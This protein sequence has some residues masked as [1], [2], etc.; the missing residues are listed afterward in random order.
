MP[1]TIAFFGATGGCTLACL[2]HTLNAGHRAIALARNPEKLSEMLTDRDMGLMKKDLSIVKG[3]VRNVED[4]L[5]VLQTAGKSIDLVI[6]GVGIWR[7]PVLLSQDT[8]LLPGSKPV[9]QFSLRTPLTM[10][11]PTIC[12]DATKNIVKATNQLNVH[13]ILV[14][15]SAHG[16]APYIDIPIWLLPMHS[17]LLKGPFDDKRAAHRAL[18]SSN[19]RWVS[20]RPSVF[21]DGKSLGLGSVREGIDENAALGWTISRADV[22]LW[23]FESLIKGP[24]DKYVGHN[25]TVTY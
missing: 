12:E 25:V 11:E 22:G 21:T 20:V 17:W 13:P 8:D 5:E 1:K 19:E 14:F 6:S 4:V 3:N 24:V 15:I 2:E 18:L 23:M 7:P 9:P 10:V 16:V